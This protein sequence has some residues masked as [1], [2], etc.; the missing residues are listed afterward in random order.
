MASKRIPTYPCQLTMNHDTRIQDQSS[1]YNIKHA[2]SREQ[3]RDK[4]ENMQS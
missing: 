1:Y 4:V 2:V 3:R